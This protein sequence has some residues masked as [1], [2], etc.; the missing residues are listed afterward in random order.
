MGNL[1]QL[2]KHMNLQIKCTGLVTEKRKWKQIHTK[3]QNNEIAEHQYVFS[4]KQDRKIV[5]KI[6]CQLAFS[7]APWLK[8][9]KRNTCDSGILYSAKTS[10][11]VTVGDKIKCLAACFFIWV[12]FSSAKVH[13]LVFFPV[14]FDSWYIWIFHFLC[15]PTRG[16]EEVKT[17]ILERRPRSGAPPAFALWVELTSGCEIPRGLLTHETELTWIR[18]SV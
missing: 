5:S 10:I 3:T 4:E 9:K 13:C 14:T 11:K 1:P 12:P 16:A 7:P 8:K 6:K 2:K 17:L 18:G 15:S